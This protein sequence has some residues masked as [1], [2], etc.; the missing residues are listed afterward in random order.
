MLCSLREGKNARKIGTQRYTRWVVHRNC[1]RRGGL[2]VQKRE[3]HRVTTHVSRRRTGGLT[4]LRVIVRACAQPLRRGAVPSRP[5][6]RPSGEST[7]RRALGRTE[8]GRR[9]LIH[10]RGDWGHAAS[11]TLPKLVPAL[12]PDLLSYGVRVEL[13]HGARV[14]VSM[15]ILVRGAALKE[16]CQPCL[17]IPGRL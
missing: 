9:T 15:G 5:E 3:E 17:S 6:G 10:V 11:R 1:S 16:I 7:G 8:P 2:N 13:P 12:R 14:A 4:A